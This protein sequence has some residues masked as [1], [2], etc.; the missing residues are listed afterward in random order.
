M[1]FILRTA[2]YHS[3]AYENGADENF[4]NNCKITLNENGKERGKYLKAFYRYNT[5][6]VV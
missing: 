1:C 2:E 4:E 6:Q 5:S 3:I